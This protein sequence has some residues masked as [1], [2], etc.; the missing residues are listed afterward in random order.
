MIETDYT[1]GIDGE[2]W[3]RP[4][5]SLR[6]RFMMADRHLDDSLQTALEATLENHGVDKLAIRERVGM[7][8]YDQVE[9]IATAIASLGLD[10]DI[11]EQIIVQSHAIAESELKAT[12]V[13]SG[14]SEDIAASVINYIRTVQRCSR[15]VGSDDNNE[16]LLDDH[17]WARQQMMQLGAAGENC[18]PEYLGAVI[19]AASFLI[20]HHPNPTSDIFHLYKRYSQHGHIHLRAVV[21]GLQAKGAK[22]NQIRA[23]LN[24]HKHYGAQL[25]PAYLAVL[26]KA[27]ALMEYNGGILQLVADFADHKIPPPL[28][29]SIVSQAGKDIGY[30]GGGLQLAMDLAA[31]HTSP[32]L[33]EAIVSK[34]HL[35]RHYQNGV[36]QLAQ[37]LLAAGFSSAMQLK[38]ID[39][40]A[41]IKYP[42]STPPRPYVLGLQRLYDINPECVEA[43]LGESSSCDHCYQFVAPEL[44]PE[45]AALASDT[46]AKNLA[47]LSPNHRVYL[48]EKL[49]DCLR[50]SKYPYYREVAFRLASTPE[51]LDLD[52]FKLGIGLVTSLAYSFEDPWVAPRPKGD[53]PT[54]PLL[55]KDMITI[56][57]QDHPKM[58]GRW[59]EALLH[60]GVDR[61]EIMPVVTIPLAGGWNN[62]RTLQPCFAVIADRFLSGDP[63][64]EARLLP[65]VA[66]LL[67]ETHHYQLSLQLA[68][69]KNPVKLICRHVFGIGPEEEA[70]VSVA[71][72]ADCEKLLD[73]NTIEGMNFVKILQLTERVSL[74][75]PAF[76]ARVRKKSHEMIERTY[77]EAVDQSYHQD[78]PVELIIGYLEIP[79]NMRFAELAIVFSN[80]KA[81]KPLSPAVMM[82]F[83]SLA[84]NACTRFPTRAQEID[85]FLRTIIS[86]QNPLYERALSIGYEPSVVLAAVAKDGTG[87]SLVRLADTSEL[88]ALTRHLSVPKVLA[89]PNVL[90]TLVPPRLT[91]VAAAQLGYAA[92]NKT[93]MLLRMLAESYPGPNGKSVQPDDDLA[94]VWQHVLE[95]RLQRPGF[96]NMG[97][98][99]HVAKGVDLKLVDHLISKMGLGTTSFT[100]IHAGKSV[101][102]P[103][104]QPIEIKIV[105]NYLKSKGLFTDQD[106]DMQ[107]CIG[108]RLCAK[109]HAA[110]IGVLNASMLLATRAMPSYAVDAWS[111]KEHNS[112][113]NAYIMAYGAGQRNRDVPY[114]LFGPGDR[115]DMLGRRDLDDLDLYQVIATLIMHYEFNGYFA[116][117]GEQFIQKAVAL[118]QRYDLYDALFEAPWVFE[119]GVTN[120]RAD[121]DTLK[122]WEMVEKFTAMRIVSESDP[123]KGITGNVRHIIR[124][125]YNEASTRFDHIRQAYPDEFGKLCSL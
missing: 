43:V 102:I 107:V 84:E 64:Q 121:A 69:G 56:T 54:V 49:F 59:Y 74:D 19:D 45:L 55:A 28:Q 81:T 11:A 48:F 114:D 110:S 18:P 53:L 37:D 124:S 44:K 108:G 115:T 39:Q 109:K 93:G 12:L 112:L 5:R 80:P 106:F 88:S 120:H 47:N 97:A 58:K 86:R 77:K 94:P 90:P 113:T 99:L 13:L 101:L 68:E 14:I 70:G 10:T 29:I 31:R 125:I 85:Q 83:I 36:V 25:G 62:D 23:I 111:T 71:D 34:C 2:A 57:G 38:V 3:Y 16:D 66:L 30:E 119:P 51:Y 117:L 17:T 82:Q 52:R 41:S 105:L 1:L 122:H 46:T 40:L 61:A 123:E 60:A 20:A 95:T 100:T 79:A 78:T 76:G 67:R 24:I 73:E 63:E 26:Q 9:N 65:V 21:E 8:R 22:P 6:E 42:A 15:K 87:E 50:Y 75:F 116:D 27:P 32:A 33:Q 103:P 91:R 4:V 92:E 118:L 72:I 98:K 35:L 89:G 104:G 7:M 96:P